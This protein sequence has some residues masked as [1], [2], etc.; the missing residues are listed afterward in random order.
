[1]VIW[2][3]SSQR[4]MTSGSIFLS[5]EAIRK[6]CTYEWMQAS[7]LGSQSLHM[8]YSHPPA[9]SF[10]FLSHSY[11]S[12]H[13]FCQRTW[14]KVL[15]SVSSWPPRVDTPQILF[16]SH[17]CKTSPRHSCFFFLGWYL[18]RITF[19]YR[20]MTYPLC[21]VGSNKNY[22]LLYTYYGSGTQC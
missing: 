2:L 4:K 5:S 11:P 22:H 1:M 9:L 15:I 19:I 16:C 3:R 7:N 8:F 12:Q 17:L 20:S 10:I 14:L 13:V 21:T 6:P 18:L